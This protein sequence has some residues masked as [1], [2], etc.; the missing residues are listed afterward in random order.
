MAVTLKEAEA[1]PESYPE[2]PEGLSAA[3][4]AVSADAIWQRLEA[5]CRARWTVREVVWMVEG[6]GTWEAPL[7]PATLNT[8]EVWEGGVWAECTPAV[9]PWGGYELPGDG[10]YRV[11]ADVGGGEVPAAVMEAFRRLAEY[12]ADTP[13]RAGVSRYSV[14]MGGAVEESY[15]RNPAWAGRAL[16]YSGAADLLRPYKRRA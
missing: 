13:D 16:E 6:Q 15:D 12:L 8:V 2:A 7:L 5:Y 11:T 3:A 9:S 14:S 4:A 1:T 10:P